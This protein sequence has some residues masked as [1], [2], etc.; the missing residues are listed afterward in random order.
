WEN[1]WPMFV[2]VQAQFVEN[3]PKLNITLH[4][5]ITGLNCYR[6][7]NENQRITV[8]KPTLPNISDNDSKSVNVTR[9]MQFPIILVH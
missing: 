6:L 4:C 2:I 7:Q 9:K 3:E 5:C 1:C 8:A